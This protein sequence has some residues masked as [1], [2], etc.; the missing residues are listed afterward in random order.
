M[1]IDWSFKSKDLN[2]ILS[3]LEKKKSL[4]DKEIS[5]TESIL[6]T[7]L[8]KLRNIKDKTRTITS[9]LAFAEKEIHRLSQEMAN[10]NFNITNVKS[11]IHQISQH[12]KEKEQEINKLI[13]FKDKIKQ[14]SS[15]LGNE[16]IKK[17]SNLN[18]FFDQ[19]KKILNQNGYITQQE[20]E[21]LKIK[22]KN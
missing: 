19:F 12:I 16:I 17:N 20:F 4:K 15:L 18:L 5:E 6:N 7:L 13:L 10:S 8:E 21:D 3:K 22:D 2:E 11:E 1:S 14:K 9:K